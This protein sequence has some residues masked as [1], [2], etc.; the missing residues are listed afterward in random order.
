MNHSQKLYRFF[1]LFLT[2]IFALVASHRLWRPGYFSMQDDIHVFRLQ[3]FDECLRD[4]QIPC[5]FISQGGLGYGYPLFN[6]YSPLPYAV[7]E[8]F[9]SLGLSLID[10]LKISFILPFFLGSVGMFLLASWHFGLVGGLIASALFTFAPY[11]AVDVFVRGALAE[12]WAI[13]LMPLTLYFI[14]QKSSSFFSLSLLL[15][16]LSHNL[17]SLYFLP[18]VILYAW[19]L[20]RLSVNFFQSLFLSFGLASFFILPAFFEKNLTTVNT[21]TQGYFSYVN[22][23]ATLSQ[24]FISRFW[25]YGASLWGPVDDMSFQIGHLHWLVPLFVLLF[26][27]RSKKIDRLPFFVFAIGLFAVFLT[28]N[29]STF[30]W[31]ALPLLQFYQFPWRFLGLA[32]L[33][34]SFVSA[35]ITRNIYLATIIIL[36]T[37]GLNFNYFHEDLW[38]SVTDSAYFSPAAIYRQSAA[39]LKDYWPSSTQEFPTTMAQTPPQFSSP[40]A[41]L[42]S[43]H[44]TSQKIQGEATNSGPDPLELILPAVYFPNWQLTINHQP[45]SYQIDPRFGQIVLS[46]PPGNS[47]FELKFTDTPIRRL[48]NIISLISLFLFIIK[49]KYDHSE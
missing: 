33:C 16:L 12:F 49:L 48:A 23:F 40:Q 47:T 5:R 43:F 41:N 6:Y 13:S 11:H 2:L 10:S 45:A 36:A 31:Q 39:G 37:I 25:G 19:Y 27:L 29:R 32:V 46:L 35:K 44:K 9:H 42:L 20:K 26:S 7:A 21:M 17:S 4:G 18:L 38:Y 8:S 30:L 34:F 24:L 14:A 22:H 15:L 3:Q 28:H 1:A